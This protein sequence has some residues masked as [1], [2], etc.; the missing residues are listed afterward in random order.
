MVSFFRFV[1]S[2]GVVV[3]TLIC[4][5]SWSFAVWRPAPP[6]DGASLWT[7]N[8]P[9]ALQYQATAAAWRQH[10]ATDHLRV[11][12]MDVRA[13]ER[14]ML[15][16]FLSGT[17]LPDLIE[18][19]RL[20]ASR[21]FIGPLSAVGF[22][23]LTD[24]LLAEGL[25]ERF[26][27]PSFTP[28][29]TRGR[30]FGLP[31]DVHPVLLAYRADLIEAAGIDLTQVETWED[32]ERALRPMQVDLD[33]D[34]RI[35]R[36]AVSFGSSEAAMIEALVLQADG[37]LFDEHDR[38]TIDLPRN[39]WT[40]ARLALWIGG[41]R[42]MALSASNFS[43]AGSQ[44]R[45][46][47][48]VL[49]SIVPDWMAG[50]WENEQTGLAG[51]VRLMPLPAWE[52]GGRRTT[53]LGGS[54][55]GI[56]KSAPDPEQAWKLA[57]R[58]Y[59]DPAFAREKFRTT[60]TISPLLDLWS[61]PIYDEPVAFFQGQRIGQLFLAAAPHV[62]RRSSSPY[63]RQAATDMTDVL[64]VLSLEAEAGQIADPAE[65]EPRA[66]ELLARVQ[67]RIE[68]D[69]SRNVFLR[70]SAEAPSNP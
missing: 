54:M 33:G 7:F 67:R 42:R 65:L 44:L 19:E 23:D 69:L 43:A 68:R 39:A 45:L 38:P 56:P 37:Q 24:R 63:V 58:L 22:A 51:K 64:R 49:C 9:R 46:Q 28:W 40:L 15:S 35:D 2:P 25:M 41:P 36:Y 11:V 10:D 16:G 61:D 52:R 21:T 20:H 13:M 14:R 31:H 5:A 29:T 48:N 18:C 3:I 8:R 70:A 53:V 26:N 60:R 17:P 62:P 32:L 4:A 55:L 57:K 12:L 34:G 59:L 1:A 47:G 6:S 50:S 27:A 30:I 66:R